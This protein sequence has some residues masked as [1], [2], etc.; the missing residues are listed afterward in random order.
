MGDL[1]DYVSLYW[2]VYPR[3]DIAKR[4]KERYFHSVKDIWC[5]S[6]IYPLVRMFGFGEVS[7]VCCITG[8][9][10]DSQTRHVSLV[11]IGPSKNRVSAFDETCFVANMIIDKTSVG[12]STMLYSYLDDR[13]HEQMYYGLDN[14]SVSYFARVGALTAFVSAV[15]YS[16]D[17]AVFKTKANHEIPEELE[18][19]ASNLLLR[20]PTNPMLESPIKTV[21][22]LYTGITLTWHFR[23]REEAAKLNVATV[24]DCKKS[25]TTP[26]KWIYIYMYS[27]TPGLCVHVNVEVEFGNADCEHTAFPNMIDEHMLNNVCNSQIG[28]KVFPFKYIK[29][30][31]LEQRLFGSATLSGKDAVKSLPEAELQFD[32][33]LRKFGKI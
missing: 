22:H 33:L 29:R 14:M 9:T 8:D 6:I 19:Y 20:V 13:I 5:N 11:L 3:I 12:P 18:H 25:E 28:E 17:R 30:G 7:T 21:K 4:Y 31:T 27:I 2:G 1:A 15:V 10:E 32:E 26:N 16:K 23:L 24:G